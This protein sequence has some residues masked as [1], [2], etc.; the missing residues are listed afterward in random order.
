[1][2]LLI[3]HLQEYTD[4]VA[5]DTPNFFLDDW[6]NLY[7]D[8]YHMHDDPDNHQERNEINCSDYRF[9]YMGAKGL[10]INS[11]NLFFLRFDMISNQSKLTND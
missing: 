10:S 1:M 5:Y 6:L 9:V 2:V 7:L 4:Y 11:S 8:K 3:E